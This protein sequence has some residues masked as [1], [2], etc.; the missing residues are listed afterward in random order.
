MRLAIG[1]KLNEL[2]AQVK[3]LALFDDIADLR[4]RIDSKPL[5]QARRLFNRG[6]VDLEP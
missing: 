3:K 1:T 5:T 2:R 4:T 6:R